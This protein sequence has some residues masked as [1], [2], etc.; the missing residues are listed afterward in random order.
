[1]SILNKSSTTPK[2]FVAEGGGR[3]T[4]CSLETSIIEAFNATKLS[5]PSYQFGSSMRPPLSEA[6][7]T[8]GAGTYAIKTTLLGKVADSK[9]RT[10]PQFSLRSR[11]AFG[12]PINR[13]VDSTMARQPGPGWYTPKQVNCRERCAAQHSF[14]RDQ[15]RAAGPK[16]D[17]SPGPGAYAAHSSVGR[18]ILSTKANYSGSGFG[19][20]ERPPLLRVHNDLGPGEYGVGIAACEKQVDS[21]K[22]TTGF[23]KFSRSTRSSE[24]SLIAQDEIRNLPGPGTY[25]LPSAICGQGASYPFRAAPK[26]SFSGRE[27]F[28]SPFAATS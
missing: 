26:P 11:E 1:M 17:R 7:E 18:Q 23:V 5:S 22:K 19:A 24:A 27:K 15:T 12:S 4:E 13:A 9:I 8:P 20:S 21:R 10:A 6:E 25:R 28:G 3:M 14:P 16:E 2:T